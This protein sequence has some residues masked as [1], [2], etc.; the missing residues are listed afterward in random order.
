MATLTHRSRTAAQQGRQAAVSKT[1]ALERAQ[2]VG[3]QGGDVAAGERLLALDDVFDLGQ[4]PR[5]DLAVGKHLVQRQAE[6]EGIGEIPDAL[7]PGDAHLPHHR[8]AVGGLL[9]EAVDAHFEAAQRLLKALLEAPAHGHHFADRLHLRGQTVVG[10]GEFLEGE[11]RDLGHHIVDAR[12]ERC[13]RGTASDLVA[14]LVE[15][16][17][18]R[19]LG[20]DLGDREAGGLGR[21]R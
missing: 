4:K 21:Q 5:I 11:T 20:G 12:L 13:W 15:R 14:Q 7:G 16:V 1:G 2:L 9:V 8:L 3:A 10:L 17:A 18:N 19:Q 6:A